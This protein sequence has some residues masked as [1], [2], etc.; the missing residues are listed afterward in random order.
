MAT[1]R[2]RSLLRL[3]ATTARL[4]L[5]LAQ[6]P[7]ESASADFGGYGQAFGRVGPYDANST[8]FLRYLENSNATGVYNI[9]GY[10]V[11]K[12]FPGEPMDGWTIRVS[13]LDIKSPG[14]I[15]VNGECG[16]DSFVGHSVQ[17]QAPD[18]LLQPNPDDDGAT[19]VVKTDPSWGM[20]TWNFYF[21]NQAAGDA[22]NNP[23][24]KPL[25][26]DGSCAGFLSDACISAL[27]ANTKYAYNVWTS[28]NASSA[29]Y[30]LLTT[31][32]SLRV[33]DE[34]GDRGPGG[35]GS[36]SLP[37]RRGVPVRFLNGS[38]T[39][40]DGW[41][42]ES[43]S[44]SA[45]ANSTSDLRAYWDSM[46]LNYWVLVTAM[47]N[48]TADP[49]VDSWDRADPLARVHCI[50]P[51]GQGT[52]KAFTFSGTVPANAEK[53]DGDQDNGAGLSAGPMGWGVWSVVV[54]SAILGSL[55][56]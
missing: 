6:S 56:W 36:S 32:D 44:A 39:S 45:R 53:L 10:D 43:R 49:E 20:C 41:E 47:V 21:P 4:S 26:A 17:I 50:A 18:A 11:S 37:S 8:E 2:P 31:C 46:V 23:S 34:C 19:K 14:S 51:N 9:P 29:R 35:A 42:Y 27:V 3:L 28:A 16:S 54:A 1:T 52:G 12:P 30:G 38:V 24:N 25:A 48:A 7:F 40:T 22:A 5:T 13:A 55:A 33:P 15:C